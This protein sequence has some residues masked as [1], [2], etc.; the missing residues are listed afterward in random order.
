MFC[1]MCKTAFS[2]KTGKK[3]VGVIH[4]PHYF[5]YLALQDPRNAVPRNP[6][7]EVCGGLPDW[8]KIL[9]LKD[10]YPSHMKNIQ[11]IY[12]QYQENLDILIPR[13]RNDV[14]H[15]NQDIRIQYLLKEI[16]EDKFKKLI[17]QRNKSLE[18]RTD[19]YNIIQTLQA[20][21][22]DTFQ[23]MVN[24]PKEIKSIVKEFD[25]IRSYVNE[26][27]VKISKTYKCTKMNIN[28]E[29]KYRKV[30]KD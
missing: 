19:I 14:V 30:V 29:W 11:N 25:V 20:V 15:S 8:R 28:K 1:V 13:L 5:A 12:Q 3:C 6:L 21:V 9:K 2:W 17:Q 10:K 26:R 27:L 23:K 4:N 24:S 16:T 22:L 7:D 18:K